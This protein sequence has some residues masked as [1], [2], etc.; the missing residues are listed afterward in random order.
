M[1]Y[2]YLSAQSVQSIMGAT[3]TFLF[4]A[5]FLA[6]IFYSRYLLIAA[7]LLQIPANYI[8]CA[9]PGGSRAKYFDRLVFDVLML[10]DLERAQTELPFNFQR[11]PFK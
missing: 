9:R 3:D 11:L 2:R 7:I 1:N 6:P 5:S 4:K 10:L 8:L